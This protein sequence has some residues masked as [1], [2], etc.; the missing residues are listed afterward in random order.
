[1]VPVASTRNQL[2][3]SWGF[4]AARAL[5]LG[6]MSY[7]LDA[8]YIEF[9]NVAAPGNPVTVPTYDR[10]EGLEY[11]DGLSA[12]GVRDY[13]R[14]ALVSNPAIGVKSGYES[15]FG[16]GEGNQLMFFAQTSGA[17]GV[18]GKT[19]SDSVNS[20]VFGAAIIA[21]PVFADPTQ[22]VIF[23]RTYLGVSE[24]VEKLASSQIGI[25]WEV[26]FL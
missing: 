24:Q 7:Q 20:K 21:T 10:S 23:A 12:S 2:Q 17:T 15:Y 26:S 16:T 19:F 25:T 14:T 3:Y 11:Y 8:M 5:G 18:H 9:E 13:I 6:D 22:D 4:I 1:M